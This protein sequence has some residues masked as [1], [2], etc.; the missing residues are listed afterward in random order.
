MEACFD[1]A[2]F[3]HDTGLLGLPLGRIM[4]FHD[5]AVRIAEARARR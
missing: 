2:H 5:Q 1:T 3:W 4:I